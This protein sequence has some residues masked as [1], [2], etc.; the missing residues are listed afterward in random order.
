M[1]EVFISFVH[2]D[3]RIATAVQHCL[4]QNLRLTERAFLSSDTFQVVAGEDWLARIKHELSSAKVVLVML[5]KRSVD[6]PWVNFEAGGAWLA[7]KNIIPV[8]FGNM[9]R[10]R[11]PNPY[12]TFQAVHLPDQQ[13]YLVS[14]VSRHLGLSVSILDAAHRMTGLRRSPTSTITQRILDVVAVSIA[15]ELR[16]FRDEE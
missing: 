9:T 2:E 11:L 12:S 10:D 8:C 7:G 13:D 3:Q 6:R 5:S 4:T 16:D 1:A 14:S 15:D